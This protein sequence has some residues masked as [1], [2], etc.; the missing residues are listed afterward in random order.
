MIV[1]SLYALS[2]DFVVA[3]LQSFHAW[4]MKRNQVRSN[5]Q[6]R[7][8]FRKEVEEKDLSKGRKK[9]KTFREIVEEK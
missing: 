3:R 7:L 1:E 4:K 9:P 5:E 6:E 8:Q 2:L